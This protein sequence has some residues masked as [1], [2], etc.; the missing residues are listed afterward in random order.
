[1]ANII[2]MCRIGITP[3]GLKAFFLDIC[4]RKN[5]KSNFPRKRAQDKGKKY[6][7]LRRK[8]KDCHCV[9]YTIKTPL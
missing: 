1:M 5:A 3:I 8:I 9:S 4:G 7:D 2:Y 6:S